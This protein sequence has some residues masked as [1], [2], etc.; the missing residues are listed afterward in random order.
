MK[1]AIGQTVTAANGTSQMF[2]NFSEKLTMTGASRH[3]QNEIQ[4]SHEQA[5]ID[6]ESAMAQKSFSLQWSFGSVRYLMPADLHYL[7][8][9]KQLYHNGK[10]HGSMCLQRTLWRASTKSSGSHK[11][12]SIAYSSRTSLAAAVSWVFSLQHRRRSL[13]EL[14][15][16]APLFSWTFP[17]PFR[18]FNV[19]ALK[20]T[21]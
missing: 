16:A 10:Y 13:A 4:I 5:K 15:L 8:I 1:P 11:S 12:P 7:L 20:S 21:A 18:I 19:D 3:F 17:Y 14:W 6:S 2:M 9:S